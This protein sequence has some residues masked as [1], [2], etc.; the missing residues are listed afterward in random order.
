LR[1]GGW[2]TCRISEGARAQPVGR[3]PRPAGHATPTALRCSYTT[4]LPYSSSVVRAPRRHPTPTV[5]APARGSRRGP[6]ALLAPRV[7]SGSCPDPSPHRSISNERVS[8]ARTAA[9]VSSTKAPGPGAG[10]QAQ[11]HAAPTRRRARSPSL[12]LLADRAAGDHA[13]AH[14]VALG[15]I[16]ARL[17]IVYGTG[18][19]VR[20]DDRAD[21][22]LGAGAEH[23]QQPVGS[24][25]TARLNGWGHAGQGRRVTRGPALARG[26]EAARG[27]R[28]PGSGAG[29]TDTGHT[30]QSRRAFGLSWIDRASRPEGALSRALMQGGAKKTRLAQKTRRTRGADRAGGHA[31]R[32]PTVRALSA[33]CRGAASRAA[34]LPHWNAGR[35]DSARRIIAPVWK[36][37]LNA[38]PALAWEIDAHIARRTGSQGPTERQ[39]ALRSA[40]GFHQL[41]TGLEGGGGIR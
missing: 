34:R 22:R 37:N 18:L 36:L 6:S 5:P 28:R 32:S 30:R 20:D 14:G 35:T 12:P 41:G 25:C 2:A 40:V 8:Q 31:G 24:A 21:A 39:L 38:G 33:S 27:A 17:R 26:C 13:L 19:A 9:R 7:G 15:K 23:A 3:E 4:A 29:C 1:S 11:D 16:V 10:S